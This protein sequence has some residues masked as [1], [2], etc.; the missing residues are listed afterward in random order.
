[1][2]APSCACPAPVCPPSC[3]GVGGVEIAPSAPPVVAPPP[4]PVE[5]GGAAPP[6][7]V[8]QPRTSA[9][10]INRFPVVSFRA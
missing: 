4:A 7:P 6:P 2:A 10:K 8:E 5:G 1:V 3:A 9:R